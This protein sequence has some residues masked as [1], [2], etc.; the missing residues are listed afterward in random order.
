MSTK[1]MVESAALLNVNVSGD[2]KR[3]VLRDGATG[4]GPR[5][6]NDGELE[7]VELATLD[8]VD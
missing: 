6:I 8:W 7:A 2:G 1:P 5:P 4:D 3:K